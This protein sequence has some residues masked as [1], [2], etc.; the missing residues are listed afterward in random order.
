MCPST[1]GPVS[2][3]SQSDAPAAKRALRTRI[4][5]ARISDPQRA[6]ADAARLARA[7]E[8]CAGHR[9]LACYASTAPEPDTLAL[10]EALADAGARV[11][12]PV[13]RSAREPAWAWYQGPDSL[14]P[15]WR[16]IPQP[17]GPVLPAPALAE[18]TFVWVSALA[19]TPAGVR[20]GTGGGWYDRAL[21]HASPRATLGTLVGDDEV[22]AALPAEPW[23][24]P[25]DLVVTPTRTLTTTA[26]RP[27][28]APPE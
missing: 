22:V 20:L 12:L 5:N 23:D 3:A 8:A 10:I 17:R 2:R 19:V 25:V 11:L 14:R 27:A 7:L 26:R 1:P 24:I 15:G 16:G 13:L 21:T 28:S 18:A 4:A 9:V 6:L